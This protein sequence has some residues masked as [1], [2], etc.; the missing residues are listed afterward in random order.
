M[1]GGSAPGQS[2]GDGSD[3]GG[4]ESPAA[5]GGGGGGASSSLVAS[6]VLGRRE[7]ALV[8]EVEAGQ[9]RP[10]PMTGQRAGGGGRAARGTATPCT[11]PWTITMRGGS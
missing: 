10:N 1:S 7:A 2:L 8:A 4:G 5:W 9:F 6:L 11:C 3:G